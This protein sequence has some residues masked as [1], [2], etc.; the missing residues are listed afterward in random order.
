[1]TRT[2]RA[3]DTPRSIADKLRSRVPAG[4]SRKT[5]AYAGAGLALAGAGAGAVT[6]GLSGTTAS[7]DTVSHAAVVAAVKHRAEA[8]S[9]FKGAGNAKGTGRTKNAARHVQTWTAVSKVVADQTY[10]RPGHTGHG[11]LPAQDQLTPVGTTGPQSWM[12]I[13]TARY[14]NARTIVRQA[15]DKHMGLRS[16][17]IAVATAMQE[18]TLQNISYGTSDSLGLFQQRPSM[19]WGTAQQV[20]NPRYASDAFL[21]ALRK[22]QVGNPGWARQPLWQSAQGVQASGFPTAYAKWE[23]QAAQLVR[24]VTTHLV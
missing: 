1:M 24:S 17:V 6:M 4:V 20:T 23:A 2:P 16:A 7:A 14:D 18:S 15:I 12:P 21:N 3:T 19:G 8:T 11:T 13:T 10:P 22:Y 5:L 9:H